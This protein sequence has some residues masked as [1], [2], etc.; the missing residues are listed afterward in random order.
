M[1]ARGA[2]R[3]R[4]WLITGA[5]GGLGRSLADAALAHGHAVIGTFR[6]A[7]QA[8]EFEARVPGRTYGCA[9]DLQDGPSIA[10]IVDAAI[11]RSNGIDVVVN[12]AGYGL[13][14]PVE[15]VT[16]AALRD[17]METNFFGPLAVIRATLPYLRRQR[18]GTIVNVSSVAGIVAGPLLGMY[19][20]SKFALEGLSA[21]LRHELAPF[22]IT[23]VI[24]E[25]GN[26]RTRFMDTA[27]A[28]VPDAIDV[29]YHEM[30]VERAARFRRSAARGDPDRM[31]AAVVACV[32][33]EAPPLRLV[34][35]PDA[36]A[37]VRAQVHAIDAELD[38][39]ASVSRST[40]FPDP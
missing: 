2:G 16:E 26:I 14:G 17:Q 13:A 22:G 7:D 35:G 3:P 15:E 28:L 29:D 10:A 33:G 21:S 40:D 31:A 11:E 36:L 9:L 8:S 27:A 37:K 18:S 12:N 39:W 20:A 5:S 6:R 23:V 25:P 38:V 34:L 30:L 1:S 19:N 4:T 24:V 32:D